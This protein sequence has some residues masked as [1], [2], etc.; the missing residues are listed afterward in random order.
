MAYPRCP[1]CGWVMNE[2]VVV[3][4]VADIELGK[5]HAIWRCTNPDCDHVEEQNERSLY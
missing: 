4:D 1:K 5:G 3:P 2:D